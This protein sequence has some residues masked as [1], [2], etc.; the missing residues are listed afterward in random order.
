MTRQNA[1]NANKTNETTRNN[2]KHIDEGSVAIKNMSQAM[3]GINDSAEKI[4]HIVKTIEEVAFQTNLLALNAAVEA[5]RAGEA[6]KGFAVVA[7]EVRNLAQRS[8]QAAKDT[9]ELIHDTVERVRTG[10]QVAEALDASFSQIEGGSQSVSRLIAE[11]TNATNEQAQGVDQVNTAMAQMDKV[12]QEN[13]ANA[14]ETASAAV[15]LSDE[16]KNLNGM[17][18][19]LVSMV[20]GK[21]STIISHSS[22]SSPGHSASARDENSFRHKQNSNAGIIQKAPRMLTGGGSASVMRPSEVIPLDDTDDF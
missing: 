11:I 5:A 8:A 4:Q 2:A 15:E 21:R 16:A 10:S 13:A 1:D 7:D 18:A 9:T 3:G 22:S 6:G 14:E 20:E 17:V 19:R 12:T